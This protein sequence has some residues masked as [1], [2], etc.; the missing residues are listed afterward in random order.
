MA[1][2]TSQKI[3]GI[4]I[5]ICLDL[6]A[7]VTFLTRRSRDGTSLFLAIIIVLVKSTKAKFRLRR[8]YDNDDGFSGW[9]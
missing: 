9:F 7:L 8:L 4:K 6:I 1:V 3:S 2:S 5:G